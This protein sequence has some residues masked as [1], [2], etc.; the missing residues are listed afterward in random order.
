MFRINVLGVALFGAMSI[1]AQAI[2]AQIMCIQAIS[3]GRMGAMNIQQ[4]QCLADVARRHLSAPLY[5]L[6]TESLYTGTSRMNE[7]KQLGQSVQSITDEI[8]LTVEIA[9]VTCGIDMS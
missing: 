4:C 9:A 8:N 3:D 7:I 6:W 2:P 5:M 1:G